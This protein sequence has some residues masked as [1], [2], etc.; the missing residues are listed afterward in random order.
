MGFV[1]NSCSP[2]AGESRL[3]G[4]SHPARHTH[5]AVTWPPT[6]EG[7]LAV[8][9]TAIVLVMLN[10]TGLLT[11][12]ARIDTA[13]I[14]AIAGAYPLGMRAFAAI[15]ARQITY[16]VTIAVAALIAVAAGEYLAA[17]E[18]I[19][20]VLVG[21]ALEHWAMHR[22]DRAIAG[23]MSLQP[24]HASVVRDGREQLVATSDV[25]LT[26]R[27]IV[28][29]GQRVPIDGVVIE[30][31][32][33]IDQSLV[34]GESMPVTKAPGSAVFCGTILE[35]GAIEIRPEL[36]GQD[37]TLARIG[38]L[39]SEAKRRRPPIVRTA[40]RLSR[41][42]LPAVLV[43]AVAVYLLTG[44]AL[45]ASAVLLVACS[46]ALVYA[47]P[48]AF[49][50]ALA[51]L[52]HDGV[53]VKGGDTLEALAGVSVVAFDKTG[54]L[55]MGRPSV[56]DVVAVSDFTPDEVMRY[57]ASVEHRSE[58]A[59][60]RAIVAEA[61]RRRLTPV[62]TTTFTSRPGLGV[63]GGVGGREV[64]VGSPV[65][66]R[67]IAASLDADVDRLVAR[68]QRAGE[69]H[70]L[71]AVDGALAGLINLRDTARPDAAAAITALR[72]VVKA[73]YMLTGDDRGVAD[74]IAA[75]VGIDPSR[76]SANLLPEQK[77]QRV[78]ELS[79]GGAKVLVVGDGVN[80]APSLAS[81]H[82]GAAFGR[83]AA[84][85]SAEA[86]QVVVLEPRL[87]TIADAIVFA[88]KT[89]QRVQ[90]N[91]IAFA[92]GVN[93]LA[94][95]A[96]GLGYLKPAASAVFHQLVSLFVILGSVS[97]LIEHR[98][99]DVEAWR[100]WRAT[101]VE[102]LRGWAAAAR[103]TADAWLRR[104]RRIVVRTTTIV[105][106]CA[107][108]LSGI[109]VLGPAEAGVV[110]RFGRLVDAD[111]QPG[112]HV[113]A[114]WPVEV[115][116]RVA[117]HRVKVLELG[118]RSPTVPSPGPMDYEWNTT[119]GE[120]QV[121]QVPDENLVLTGDENMSELYAVV[122]YTMADPAKYLFAVR[123]GDALVRMMA[124]GSLR[125]IA[126]GY[127]LDGL[128]TTER[129]ALEEQWT[130]AIRA[131]LAQIGA[132]VEVL[133]IHLADVHPPVDVVD[134]FRDVAS[135]EEDQVMR[136]NEADAYSKEAIPVARGNANAQ[137]E[138]A[139]GYKDSRVSQSQGD[140]ARFLGRLAQTSNMP[141]TMFRL[142][143]EAIDAVLPGKRVIITDDRKG[144]RRSLIFV[145]DGDLLKVLGAAR[146]G[147]GEPQD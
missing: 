1:G 17:A 53:L 71:V 23:L 51:R 145:G 41:V 59:L 96:A 57:A 33:A 38:R 99:R 97:L 141:L 30:G 140:A 146:P 2:P 24:D 130:D 60:G 28:R 54:T 18:V 121:Q 52:A 73:I 93:T 61:T 98:L 34:T 56:T 74:A 67:E 63:I 128:L 47:A 134:A 49:T 84:D 120:G 22:A 91:V 43:S 144:G 95:L 69:T 62:P 133:G 72:P 20:I 92:I 79:E 83:G 118:F 135:A 65:F 112:L 143:M 136:V 132:G 46:C 82:V 123:D 31:Q 124:E 42:F 5:H 55:T 108:L 76:V 10:A 90:F 35:H 114:P 4:V 39:V 116:T 3:G 27:V 137:R 101:A 75:E 9:A 8:L 85:L 11:T 119:H 104:H 105:L 29:G 94:I 14:V 80:D 103:D 87:G 138:I 131:R 32:A 126:A 100:G 48:A 44:Q 50:A 45:R 7:R 36:V 117:P 64:A 110:Q 26:D 129:R 86:A 122:H 102:R 107:W 12:I 106:A 78:H 58:H 40:D 6:R 125:S 139:S 142:Q 147:F 81:A 16:D 25:Q 21:D 15:K 68:G 115:V 89:V 13:L 113:R 127:A 70:V 77:L 19:L 88:R 66:V 37:A 111:L 109:V